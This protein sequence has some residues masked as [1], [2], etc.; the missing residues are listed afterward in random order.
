MAQLPDNLGAFRLLRAAYRPTTG[1]GRYG[2]LSRVLSL[3][4]CSI[5]LGFCFTFLFLQQQICRPML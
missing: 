1:I 4:V 5:Y 2:S 3:K